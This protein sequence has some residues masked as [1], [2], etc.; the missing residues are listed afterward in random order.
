MSGC[1][2]DEAPAVQVRLSA[3]GNSCNSNGKKNG[4]DNGNGKK[5]GHCKDGSGGSSGSGGATSTGGSPSTGGA[6]SGDDPSTGGT[7]SGGGATDPGP[8]GSGGDGG[9]S[10]GDDHSGGIS[11]VD[12]EG[13]PIP[14]DPDNTQ[15]QVETR[16]ETWEPALDVSV[17]PDAR[18]RLDVVLVA[19]NSGGMRRDLDL[20]KGAL[21]QFSGAL[22]GNGSADRVSLVRVSTDARVVQPLTSDRAALD[23]AIDSL[24]VRNGWT[25]LWDG[26][27]IA[28][29]V[30]S[31][32]QL[33]ATDD[34]STCFSGAYPVILAI[35]D[36]VENNSAGQNNTNYPG[37]GIDTYFEDIKDL[38]AGAR[39]TQ[40]HTV[41]IGKRID[42]P[43][44][45]ELSMLSGGIYRSIADYQ[46]L[47]RA[48]RSTSGQLGSMIPVCFRPA[49]CS[50]TEVRVQVTLEHEGQS[51]TAEFVAPLDPTCPS[52]Q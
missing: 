45:R 49:H 44:L 39:R 7:S 46:E 18:P 36:G 5:N 31:A 22:L 8:G 21:A 12:R 48:L 10:G 6:A 17:R 3:V 15:V 19:D 1:A 34:G 51:H 25:A 26:V 35:T 16:I 20:L 32:G 50:H 30:L 24:V 27:R 37:D 23:G 47:V 43:S 9:S 42:E 13:D 11:I 33:D 41:G 40:I 28:N 29:Q 38:H 2:E 14:F 4:T 52:E